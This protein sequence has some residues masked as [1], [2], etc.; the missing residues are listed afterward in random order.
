MKGSDPAVLVGSA[1]ALTLVAAGAG[2]VPAHRASN[3]DPMR[4]LRYE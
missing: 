1:V 3:V 4:A 2:L